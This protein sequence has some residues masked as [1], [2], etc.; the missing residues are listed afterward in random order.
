MNNQCICESKPARLCC[1][2]DEKLRKKWLFS[3]EK[4]HEPLRQTSREIAWKLKLLSNSNRLE[5]L[6]MLSLREHCMDEI[7][8]KLKLQKSAISY[9]LALLKKHGMVCV[10]KRSRFAFYALSHS[11]KKA[12]VAFGNI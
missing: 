6:L 11:G 9:H 12:I 7:A 4:E 2:A 3:L 5:I 10:K 8:R 1:P